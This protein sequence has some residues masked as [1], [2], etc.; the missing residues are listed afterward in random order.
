MAIMAKRIPEFVTIPR[1]H[2]ALFHLLRALV[3]LG[4]VIGIGLLASAASADGLATA[5]V[6]AIALTGGCC[7]CLLILYYLDTLRY[8][9]SLVVPFQSPYTI[10]RTVATLTLTTDGD[11]HY[12]KKQE[13]KILVDGTAGFSSRHLRAMPN[14]AEGPRPELIDFLSCNHKVTKHTNPDGTVDAHF[15]FNDGPKK[16]GEVVSL[17]WS[18]NFSRSFPLCEEFFTVSFL[19][20]A[21][22][23]ELSIKYP[24]DRP[25][26]NVWL[27]VS[28]QGSAQE[29]IVKHDALIQVF[30]G[31]LVKFHLTNPRLNSIYAVRWK[32]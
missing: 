4:F 5:D 30:D 17:E 10:K 2:S 31:Q 21:D 19:Y 6:F 32:W 22:D 16:K 28:S 14:P 13:L 23:Y 8:Y 29:Y 24:H 20:P 3:V 12:T 7:I 15:M 18:A 25:C 1:R 27:T 9:V 11:G 26:K